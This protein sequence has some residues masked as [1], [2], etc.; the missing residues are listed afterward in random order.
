ML[1][2]GDKEEEE[3]G[4]C[5]LSLL[6][7]RQQSSFDDQWISSIWEETSIH[8]FA[9]KNSMSQYI[10]AKQICRFL[11]KLDGKWWKQWE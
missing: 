2:R 4:L 10:G 1:S 8:T 11:L 6:Q 7:A 9:F 5:K 3:W